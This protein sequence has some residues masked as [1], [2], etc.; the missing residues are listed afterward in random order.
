MTSLC[1]VLAAIY[2][3]YPK[4]LKEGNFCQEMRGKKNREDINNIRY[5]LQMPF[6]TVLLVSFLFFSNANMASA[7]SCLL[8]FTAKGVKVY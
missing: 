8:E 4:E 3:F 6:V 2:F 5:T 1:E 7:G